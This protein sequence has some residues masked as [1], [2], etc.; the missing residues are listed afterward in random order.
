MDVAPAMNALIRKLQGG[1]DDETHP[2]PPPAPIP[3]PRLPVQIFGW[4]VAVRGPS[5]YE[6]LSETTRAGGG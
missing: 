6:L 5:L 3:L 4:V 1:D 2:P